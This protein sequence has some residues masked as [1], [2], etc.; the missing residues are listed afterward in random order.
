MILYYWSKIPWLFI[1]FIKPD[2]VR[3]MIRHAKFIRR[4]KVQTWLCSEINRTF[5]WRRPFHSVNLKPNND[6]HRVSDSKS[7]RLV[8][9]L[10]LTLISSSHHYDTQAHVHRHHPW[11]PESGDLPPSRRAPSWVQRTPHYVDY[12]RRFRQVEGRILSEFLGTQQGE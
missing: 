10:R 5:N 3:V 6:T 11:P 12:G 7:N 2:S 9:T 4:R 1:D 8:F